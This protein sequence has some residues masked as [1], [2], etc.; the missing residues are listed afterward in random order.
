[1]EKLREVVS[2][3]APVQFKSV[4]LDTCDELSGTEVMD[5]LRMRRT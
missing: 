3:D 2:G 4:C 5:L 1:M